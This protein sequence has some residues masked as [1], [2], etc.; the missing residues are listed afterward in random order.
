MSA[1]IRRIW[2]PP[3]TGKTTTLAKR[4]QATVRERGPESISIASFSVTAAQEIA[5][6]A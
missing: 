6:D 3:G 2:G 4:V 1:T 5:F